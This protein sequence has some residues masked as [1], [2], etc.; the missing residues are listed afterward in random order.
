MGS[1]RSEECPDATRGYDELYVCAGTYSESCVGSSLG[2]RTECLDQT[3]RVEIVSARLRRL[4]A[5]GNIIV[6]ER[7]QMTLCGRHNAC[8]VGDARAV[9]V[10]ARMSRVRQI[11]DSTIE[12]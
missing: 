11:K 9:A 1:R 4:L 3:D 2:I 8:A 10:P 12:W 7:Q 5:F 6:K